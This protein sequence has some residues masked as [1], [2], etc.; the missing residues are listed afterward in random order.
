MTRK[1][2][3]SA[4]AMALMAVS[5]TLY[6]TYGVFGFKPGARTYALSVLLPNS[7]GLMET[8]PVTL[9]GLQVGR[10]RGLAKAEHGVLAHL[11]VESRYRIPMDAQVIVA[12]LSA[13]GEQYINFAPKSAVGPYFPDG[14]LVPDGQ[15][16]QPITM[17]QALGGIQGVM[18]QLDTDAINEILRG[19]DTA[20]RDV[21]PSIAKLVNSGSMF[22]TTLR[23][24]RELIQRLLS[25]A[26]GAASQSNGEKM[27]LLR[28]SAE[29]L[30]TTFAPELPALLDQFIGITVSSGG[31]QVIPFI[32]MLKR[33]MQYIAVLVGDGGAAV[34]V[35]RPYLLDPLEGVDLDP[36]K[37]MDGLLA[38]FPEGKGF[39]LL[40]DIPH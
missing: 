18:N 16:T 21:G 9:N 6:L 12:N 28:S 2:L 29:R 22:S 26:A 40:V 13:V 19:A 35:I 17:A 24:N 27:T 4:L 33:L 10:V 32:P 38:A 5:A 30:A 37:T 14:A 8:S 23:Q 1:I 11:A 15:V 3:V 36:G 25:F 39:R 31:T 7:G 34:E 20:I